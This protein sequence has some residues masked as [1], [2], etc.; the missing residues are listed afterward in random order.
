MVLKSAPCVQYIRK[1]TGIMALNTV[2]L[3]A[4]HN[5]TS[6]MQVVAYKMKFSFVLPQ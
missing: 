3:D 2:R 5:G 4:G 6:R 1:S